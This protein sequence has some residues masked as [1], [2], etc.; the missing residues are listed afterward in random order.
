MLSHFDVGFSFKLDGLD[1]LISI[2]NTDTRSCFWKSFWLRLWI[3]N[4]NV[5]S[6]Q[7]RFRHTKSMAT[8]VIN[9][10][11]PSVDDHLPA[12]LNWHRSSYEHCCRPCCG[13]TWLVLVGVHYI[14][15]WFHWAQLLKHSSPMGFLHMFIVIVIIAPMA[16]EV[17]NLMQDKIFI[18]HITL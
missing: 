4:K 7:S 3:R 17:V 1:S 14:R 2:A 10:Y 8:S 18:V 9:C 6:C 13:C 12:I 16:A 11:Q 15:W 5:Q